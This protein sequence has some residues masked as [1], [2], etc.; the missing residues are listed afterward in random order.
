MILLIKKI[1]EDENVLDE[2]ILKAVPSVVYDTLDD[3]CT[4]SPDHVTIRVSN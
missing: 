1:D 2:E 4:N 3:P